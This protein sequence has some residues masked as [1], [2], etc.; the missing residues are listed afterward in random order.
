M[1][2]EDVWVQLGEGQEGLYQ[3]LE[4]HAG[5]SAETWGKVSSCSFSVNFCLGLEINDCNTKS[6]K[7]EWISLH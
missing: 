2:P 1:L 7:E 5:Q 3:N 4:C 6:G